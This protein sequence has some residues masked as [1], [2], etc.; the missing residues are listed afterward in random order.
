[1]QV[2]G[3]I[4]EDKE[5]RPW[6]ILLIN[7]ACIIK[8]EKQTEDLWSS[9]DHIA[10]PNKRD[11]WVFLRGVK[12]SLK[13]SPCFVIFFVLSTLCQSYCVPS[14]IVL[15]TSTLPPAPKIFVSLILLY[16]LA[17]RTETRGWNKVEDPKYIQNEW[18]TNG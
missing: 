14:Y 4:R 16:I 15:P 17:P 8:Q 6:E 2:G 1:M 13:G 3:N 18:K 9:R 5:N 7:H 11:P 12:P 10:P